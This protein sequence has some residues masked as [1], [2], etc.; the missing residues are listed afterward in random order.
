MRVKD[1]NREKKKYSYLKSLTNLFFK[2]KEKYSINNKRYKN[3]FSDTENYNSEC[4]LEINLLKV[5]DF[6]KSNNESFIS[7]IASYPFVQL[8]FIFFFTMM[9][10][11]IETS[12][13]KNFGKLNGHSEE[14]LWYASFMWKMINF[15]FFPLWGYFFDKIGFKRF[16]RI[17]ISLEI[18]ISAICYYISYNKYGFI[19]YCIISALVNSASLAISPTNFGIIFDNEK[20]AF[21]FGISCFLTNTFYVFRPLIDNLLTHKIYYLILYLILTLF[22]MLG[23]II[24]CFFIDQ[25]H[26]AY[27]EMDSSSE[28]NME[29]ELKDLNYYDNNEQKF[30]PKDNDDNK[31]TNLIENNGHYNNSDK[32]QN[33]SQINK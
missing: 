11:I 30:N 22:S 14:F 31:K 2:K 28:D 29:I 20:G 16:Y 9:F 13:M 33:K 10:G 8:T 25:K 23:F 32:E 19:F 4:P 27:M 15:L 21:L 5:N 18:L 24:L 6:D 26:V 7:L 12:S 17:I 3:E 1:Q